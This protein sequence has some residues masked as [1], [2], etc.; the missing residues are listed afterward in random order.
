MLR[1]Y[2]MSSYLIFMLPAMILAFIAQIRVSSAFSKYSKIRSIK[3]ITAQDVASAI[4]SKAGIKDVRVE[5]INGNLNDHYDPKDKVIRLSSSVYNSTSIAALG[6]AA[7]EAGHAVQHHKKYTPLVFRNAIVPVTRLASSLA[8]PLIFIGFFLSFTGLIWAGIIFFSGAVVFQII[9][10]PVEF[11]ASKNA[12]IYLEQE[13][14]LYNEE[15]D[16]A[17]KVLNAAALTYVA[18]LLVS[19]M[20]LLRFVSLANR[21]N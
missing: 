20:Q 7:H 9:T 18:A 15:I 17:K 3:N 4:L 6:I 19:L 13:G 14:I 1:Y 5:P 11:N 8:I 12:L 21:R 16:G 10:L 2:D